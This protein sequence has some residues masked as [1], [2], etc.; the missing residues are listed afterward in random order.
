MNELLVHKELTEEHLSKVCAFWR[1]KA[2][3]YSDIVK[4]AEM[5]NPPA[6]NT[7]WVGVI[8]AEITS[9]KSLIDKTEDLVKDNVSHDQKEYVFG[10]AL[11]G[12]GFMQEGQTRL[13]KA[14]E[15]N[16]TDENIRGLNISLNDR[17]F[18]YERY[19]LSK[20]LLSRNENDPIALIIL[21]EVLARYGRWLEASAYVKRALNIWPRN[22]VAHEWSGQSYLRRE[23][24]RSALLRFKLSTDYGNKDGYPVACVGLCYFILGKY[25]KAREYVKKAL[26]IELS[27]RWASD[28]LKEIDGDK[29]CGIEY[30][31][32]FHNRIT[33]E[34]LVYEK[35]YQDN[36]MSHLLYLAAD[37]I[38]TKKTRKLK[39]GVSKLCGKLPEEVI[40]SVSGRARFI[41][42]EISE[43]LADLR[44]AVEIKRTI[45]TVSNLAWCLKNNDSKEDEKVANDLDEELITTARYKLKKRSRCFR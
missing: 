24:Y 45:Q 5:E 4:K 42:G 39:K 14:V 35:K 32:Y 9:D 23:K 43:G 17:E 12:M 3:N 27:Q 31:N 7:F 22:C 21:S 44:R 38:R 20:K 13:R 36:A 33:Y 19:L 15:L 29:S 8:Q 18:D 10:L 1:D 30:F 26:D 16:P 28:L 41:A 2:K 34:Y 25:N 6:I 40:L 11:C 37:G